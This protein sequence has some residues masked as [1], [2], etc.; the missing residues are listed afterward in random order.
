MQIGQIE[1]IID[2]TITDEHLKDVVDAGVSVD[3]SWNSRGWYAR[4]GMVTIISVDTG[5]VVDV[6]FLSNSCSA[7]GQKKREQQEG[8]ILRRESEATMGE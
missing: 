1:G 6:I 5:K 7:C 8:T 4:Y 3:G 2:D